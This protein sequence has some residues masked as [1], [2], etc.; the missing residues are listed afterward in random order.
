[1]A[2]FLKIAFVGSHGV[3]KTTLVE[4]LKNVLK[5]GESNIVEETAAKVFKMGETDPA[6]QINQGATLEA[7]LKII[8]MQIEEENAK[9]K[10]LDTSGVMAYANSGENKYAN[11]L[12]CD[13]TAF[14]ALAYTHARMYRDDKYKWARP[15]CGNLYTWILG[16][17]THNYD[18][19][20]YLPVSFPIQATDVRPGDIDFQ[21]EMDEHLQAM[22]LHNRLGTL[23]L[24]AGLRTE[25]V[26][27]LSGP[28]ER[29]IARATKAI[30]EALSKVDMNGYGFGPTLGSIFGNRNLQVNQYPEYSKVS[31]HPEVKHGHANAITAGV[32][33]NSMQEI[34]SAQHALQA[35]TLKEHF[36]EAY[37]AMKDE[38]ESKE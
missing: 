35:K 28:V 17:L 9:G 31:S 5:L 29:R 23:R 27:V 16:A 22:F 3:G 8:G 30:D 34:L 36:N 13:R 37:E 4:E 7:Q 25:Q 32:L 2:K 1:M 19:V 11:L 21:E 38:S 33:K 26:V 15:L 12:L 14:D 10:A 18:I 24:G 20:F 6:L